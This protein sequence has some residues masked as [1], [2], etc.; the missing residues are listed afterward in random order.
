MQV[1]DKLVEVDILELSVFTWPGVGIF[2]ASMGLGDGDS[3]GIKRILGMAK[4]G[5]TESPLNED[6]WGRGQQFESRSDPQ[7]PSLRSPF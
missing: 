1:S 3:D 6:S 4:R 7:S 2:H 5:Y